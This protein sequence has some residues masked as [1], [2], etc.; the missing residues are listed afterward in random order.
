MPK[1]FYK[2]N[3]FTGG[4]NLIRDARDIS[5]TELTQADNLSLG[6]AGSISTANEIYGT[7]GFIL[8]VNKYVCAGGGL[9]YFESDREGGAAANDVGERWTAALDARTAE[10]SLKGDVTG[11]VSAATDMGVITTKTFSAD[12]LEFQGDYITRGNS[13]GSINFGD[14]FQEGDIL[15]ITGCTDTAAN[16]RVTR[17]SNIYSS[18][19]FMATATS[20]TTESSEAGTVAI[21]RLDNVVFFASYDTL[22]VAD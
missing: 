7:D 1:Q 15:R 10:L 17:V 6:V 16:N 13:G 3:D 8:P 9:Y 18:G 19:T 11:T 21:E 2:L 20:F 12:E 4:L 5:P 14:S 22:R